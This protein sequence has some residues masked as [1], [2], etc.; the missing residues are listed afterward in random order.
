MMP[1]PDLHELPH[2][3]DVAKLLIPME[4]AASKLTDPEN[5]P[6]LESISS[7]DALEYFYQ[8]INNLL[9]LHEQVSK[10]IPATE[11]RPDEAPDD[12]SPPMK[13]NTRVSREFETPDMLSSPSLIS[14]LKMD[15][16]QESLVSPTMGT[17]TEDC[18]K[19]RLSSLLLSEASAVA[20]LV[21]EIRLQRERFLDEHVDRDGE[22][23]C[24]S[25]VT[26]D[27]SSPTLSHGIKPRRSSSRRSHSDG[28]LS[29]TKVA[30]SRRFWSK[31]E[32]AIS[33]KQYLDRMH[34]YCPVSTSVY[35]TAAVYIYRLCIVLQMVPLTNLSVHRLTLACLRVACKN[36]EDQTHPQKRYAAVGGVSLS[37]LYRLEITLLFL[38]EFDVAIDSQVL[39]EFLKI[40]AEFHVQSLRIVGSKNT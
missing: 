34:K 1:W 20:S 29:P 32:P 18:S 16:P 12:H 19:R 25:A 10:P 5:I 39:T 22:S 37:D 35:I 21:N 31:H 28:R 27:S 33:V 38:L 40:I 17:G 7:E 36:I 24:E 8:F 15:T 14:P 23:D 3:P 6:S 30:I 2:L 11:P 9:I 4:L 26:E 13:E